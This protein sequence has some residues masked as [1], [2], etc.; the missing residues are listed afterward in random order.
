VVFDRR[1]DDFPRTVPQ[2]QLRISTV[3][4]SDQL[5]ASP[6][7]LPYV[8]IGRAIV[9]AATPLRFCLFRSSTLIPLVISARP[10][11]QAELE[12]P[13]LRSER[14]RAPLGTGARA[15]T[16]RSRRSSIRNCVLITPF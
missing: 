5:D 4:T 10:C 12:M 6:N 15:H 11:A 3:D 7:C 1:Y 16:D 13:E 8:A 2:H 14:P 9:A